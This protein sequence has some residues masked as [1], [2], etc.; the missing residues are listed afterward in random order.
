M[1]GH[2]DEKSGQ[3]SVFSSVLL[4]QFLGGREQ[5]QFKVPQNHISEEHHCLL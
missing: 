1:C 3:E 5:E 4:M 2:R